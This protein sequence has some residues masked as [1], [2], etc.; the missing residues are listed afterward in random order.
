MACWLLLF[1][2]NAVF[3]G[4][5]I[6]YAIVNGSGTLLADGSWQAVAT[7]TRAADKGGANVS[8]YTIKINASSS[9]ASGDVTG[10]QVTDGTDIWSATGSFGAGDNVVCTGPA[11]KPADLTI[12]VQLAG[13]A[14]G[15]TV[16]VS[17]QNEDG[18][19]A[20]GLPTAD[21][22]NLNI[23]APC[24]DSDIATFTIT[25][26]TDAQEIGGTYTIYA[27][28]GVESAPLTMTGVQFNLNNT[29]WTN[30]TGDNGSDS[31]TIDWATSPDGPATIQV[32]GY[33]PDC[34]GTNLITSAVRNVTIN[35]ACSDGDLAV[36]SIADPLDAATISGVYRVKL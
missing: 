28:V 22:S 23:I 33:D 6:N 20:T 9:V 25:D 35:N 19:G 29:G 18:G 8:T 21:S 24:V 12:N 13:S 10:V 30:S 27:Q 3:A 11:A 7:A 4:S 1:L 31:Y 32:R 26:P 34:G 2:P 5:N 17:I 14:D 36:I 15:R 16:G